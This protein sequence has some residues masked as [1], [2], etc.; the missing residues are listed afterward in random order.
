MLT[1]FP[2]LKT[3]LKKHVS[4]VPSC[5]D[6]VITVF[7]LSAQFYIEDTGVSTLLSHWMWGA[8][9]SPL[10]GDGL[11]PLLLGYMNKSK[12][13]TQVLKRDLPGRD[14]WTWSGRRPEIYRNSRLF[15]YC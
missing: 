11:S 2:A 3:M 6:C 8:G 5:Y 7:K 4:D 1:L 12:Y 13:V 15:D 14:V 9:S 10:Q